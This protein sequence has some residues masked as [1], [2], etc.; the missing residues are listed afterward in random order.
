MENDVKYDIIPF[1]QFKGES[2]IE[3]LN[4]KNKE[5]FDIRIDSYHGVVNDIELLKYK[6]SKYCISKI[7]TYY[8]S[9]LGINGL[10]SI[11]NKRILIL[12]YLLANIRKRFC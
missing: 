1:N 10:L 4:V 9:M 8:A 11:V 3:L 2:T 12:N 6:W 7:N 5:E